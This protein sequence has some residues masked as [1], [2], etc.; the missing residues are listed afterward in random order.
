MKCPN[1]GETVSDEIP[2]CPICGQ[3]LS[4]GRSHRKLRFILMDVQE[5]RRFR[6]LASAVIIGIVIVAVLSV[7]LTSI[8]ETEPEITPPSM[9]PSESALRVPGSDDYIEFYEGFDDPGF[10]A[11]WVTEKGKNKLHITLSSKISGSYTDFSWIIRNEITGDI[12]V[13]INKLEAEITWANPSVGIYNITIACSSDSKEDYTHTGRMQYF[14]D[15]IRTD[16]FEYGGRTYSV[17]TVVRNSEYLNL[18]SQSDTVPRTSSSASDSA[19]FAEP[20]D[21]VNLLAGRLSDA[22]LRNNPDLKTNGPEFAS[23]VM[24][25]IQSCYR[26]VS[27]TLSHST[28]VYWAYP[29][30][31]IYFHQGDSGDLSLLLASLL[32]ASGYDSGIMLMHGKTFAAVALDYTPSDIPSGLHSISLSYENR[33][34]ILLEPMES[35]P[36]GCIDDAF[37]YRFGKCYY[38]GTATDDCGGFASV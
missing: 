29:G 35:F 34:Y 6:H 37:D 32:K 15:S 4:S 30:E 25:Y 23:F 17:E 8:G 20:T 5:D 7:L 36:L 31:T 12:Q 1:C 22:F 19:S 28:P 21:S 9:G 27:D 2:F 38:Y 3:N 26:E 10:S 24:T 14:G 11:G 13:S 33:R 16:A 18:T